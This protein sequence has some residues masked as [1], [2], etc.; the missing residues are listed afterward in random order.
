MVSVYGP[1][2]EAV[3]CREITKTFETIRRL[4]LG[5]LASWVASDSNQ[6]RGESVIVVN[7]APRAEKAEGADYDSVLLPLIAELPL[8]QAVA[9][10]VSITGAPKNAL[11]ER[12]LELKKAAQG[13]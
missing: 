7:A 12:A 2:R 10:A 5:E 11:Y 1:E 8:K 3:L 9:L 6:E 4:P 13:A